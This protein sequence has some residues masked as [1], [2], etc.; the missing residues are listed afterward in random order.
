MTTRGPVVVVGDPIDPHVGAVLGSLKRPAVVFDASSLGQMT[1]VLHGTEFL[2]NDGEGDWILSSDG[3]NRGWLRR[4]A[5]AGW[6]RGLEL[7]SHGAAVQSAWLSLLSGIARTCSVKWLTDVDR[8]IV[9]ENKTVQAAAAN[10][11]QI[12]TPNFLVT[13]S[14]AAVRQI[15]A[16]DIVVKPLG[17]GDYTE[18]GKARAVFATR[19]S[20]TD[21]RLEALGGAPFLVQ[22]YVEAKR[23]YRVVTVRD[24]AW[25]AYIDAAAFSVDWRQDPRAHRSFI[26]TKVPSTIRA[27]AVAIAN[28]LALGYSSQ[29]WIVTDDGRHVL[30]DVNP[31]GQWLFLPPE[32]ADQVTTSIA[33]WL[34]SGS[35][36]D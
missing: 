29:D 34:S 16:G 17:A 9:T 27:G 7:D 8:L 25:A 4:L 36:N 26:A 32:I 19:M 6:H 14:Q 28:H 2:V 30:L 10:L 13:N 18:N 31:A 12:D 3:E 21:S 23:H 5:P 15:F 24:E 20:A 35:Q 1:F 11:L 33:G 22:E